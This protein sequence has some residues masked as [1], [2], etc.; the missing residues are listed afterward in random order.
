MDVSTSNA[1]SDS[2]YTSAWHLTCILPYNGAA[3]GFHYNGDAML[4]TNNPVS[5]T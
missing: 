1:I 4:S 3:I 5:E 2:G